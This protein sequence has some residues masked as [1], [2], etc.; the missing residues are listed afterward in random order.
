VQDSKVDCLPGPDFPVLQIAESSLPGDVFIVDVVAIGLD[1][2]E[3][4][5]LIVRRQELTLFWER[6]DR[7]P[8][9][10][11]DDNGNTTFDDEDP[12][13]T[14]SQCLLQRQESYIPSPGSVSSNAVHPCDKR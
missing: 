4:E 1:A 6:R 8:A 12:S 5:S 7:W 9:C 3:H 11:T 10:D 2:C 13:N 14:V